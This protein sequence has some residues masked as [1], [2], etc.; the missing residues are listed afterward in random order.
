[1][2]IKVLAKSVVNKISAGEV[3]EK[4]A[5]I[6]K[7]LLENSI[8]AGAKNIT[9]EIENGGIDLIKIIDD[10]CGI[11]ESEI[12]LA[13]TPHAT[14]KLTQIED[15]EKLNTMGFRGEAL[16]SISAISRVCITTKTNIDEFATSVNL[17][18]GEEVS[19]SQIAGITGT[20]IEVR[21]VFYNT[22]ARLK[23]LRKPKT[24][25]SDITGYVEKII[26]SH[27]DIAFKYIVNGK[28]IYN[29]TC[30]SVLNNIY[31][32]FGK[33]TASG[34]LGVEYDLGGYS[35]N[36]Y[37][38]KPELCKANRTYQNLF[39][40]GRYC[41]NALVSTAV[42]NAFENFMMKGKFPLFVLFINLPQC[43]VDVNVHPNKLEVKFA[44]TSK[45][46]KL[47]CD[48]VYKALYEY[49]HIRNV[50][51]DKVI[52]QEEKLD[53]LPKEENVQSLN[54]DEGVS[55]NDNLCAQEEQIRNFLIENHKNTGAYDF[56]ST[57]SLVLKTVELE[58]PKTLAEFNS[59]NIIQINELK[60]ENPIKQIT[61]KQEDYKLLFDDEYKYIGKI[62]N[63]YLILEQDDRI[64]FIDQHAAHERQKYDALIKQIEESSL[65]KQDYLVP[66]I[67]TVSGPEY[68]FLISNLELLMSFGID[69]QE[70]GKNSFR[71]SS[72]PMVLGDIDIKKYFDDLLGNISGLA[73]TPKEIIREKFMQMACKSAIKGGDDL[74]DFE[75]KY[76]LKKLKEETKVL[77]CPHGRPIIVEV[78]KKQIEK[79]FKRIVD[80]KK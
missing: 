63:T 46:Y 80:W 11:S 12:T 41:N 36:G 45:I 64:Y 79:W 31:T 65:S 70:F 21:N 74:S 23:F 56:E 13:F 48:A 30:G 47:V 29:T 20:K 2:G 43:D 61:P 25:E 49:N 71:V 4:P 62:F 3:V 67:F 40:N 28:L 6:V 35:I 26:L 72:V 1:M 68:N 78:D 15:L 51:L 60:S 17:E 37:I 16:A 33:E 75:I 19:R 39:V 38:C 76:L 59:K 24:E 34:V 55:Y 50:E 18:G 44:D 52:K 9:I 54:K 42:A 66:Y 77:L 14:S 7:E 32:I 69:I 8:D 5:S 58:E 53:I 22:P 57:N 27:S 73:K 10:G